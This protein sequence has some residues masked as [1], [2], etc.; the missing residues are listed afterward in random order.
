MSDKKDNVVSIVPLEREKQKN[1]L[2]DELS[3]MAGRTPQSLKN[4]KTE[5]HFKAKERL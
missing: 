4:A 3:R 5:A 1:K 2:L